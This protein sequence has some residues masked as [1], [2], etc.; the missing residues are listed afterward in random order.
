MT[1]IM[2]NGLINGLTL[3]VLATAFALIYVPLRIFAISLA[4]LY[5]IAPFVAMEVR[6]WG[7]GWPLALIAALLVTT[8]AAAM[9]ERLNHL[10]LARA[11]TTAMG[12]LV[13]S[14]G[15]YIVLVQL[16]ALTW[17]NEVRMLRPGPDTSLVTADLVFNYTQILGAIIAVVTLGVL[18]AWL[19][20]TDIG[21]RLR[22]MADSPLQ[23]TLLG[24]DCDTLRLVAAAL[25]GLL[26]GIG[27]LITASS[28]GI[29]PQAGLHD[30]LLAVVAVIIGGSRSF[31]GALVGS[32]VLG[33]VRSQVVWHWSANWQDA[34][35]FFLLIVMLYAQ[36]NGLLVHGDRREAEGA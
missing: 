7:A 31:F 1:Q 15:I 16:V 24:Y 26:A 34:A 17:G 25:G 28:I 19:W 21:L 8:F 9:I 27:G 20:F 2:V 36:P 22:A 13:S 3:A 10:P 14:L 33:I 35:S 6:H 4:G 30:L 5:V 11:E 23:L 32:L 18:Y 29:D 12:H